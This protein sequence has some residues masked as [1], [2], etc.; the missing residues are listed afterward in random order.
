M[1]SNLWVLLAAACLFW[2]GC[3]R[4]TATEKAPQ[5]LGDVLAAQPRK[6]EFD[7]T[8]ADLDAKAEAATRGYQSEG[9]PTVFTLDTPSFALPVSAGH[10]YRAVVRL[11][12]DAVYSDLAERGVRF[13]VILPG[14]GLRP[15]GG[16]VGPGAIFDLHCASSDGKALVKLSSSVPDLSVTAGVLAKLGSGTATVQ[17]YSRVAEPTDWGGPELKD[18]LEKELLGFAIAASPVEGALD[19]PTSV[20]FPLAAGWC[21]K[22]AVVLRPGA[23]FGSGKV[24]LVIGEAVTRGP[25]SLADLGCVTSDRTQPLKLRSGRGGHGGFVAQLYRKP[26]AT[27]VAAPVVGDN[28]TVCAKCGAERDLCRAQKGVGVCEGAWNTCVRAHSGVSDSPYSYCR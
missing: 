20:S 12:P 14:K 23:A 13:D 4:G 11:G 5:R 2:G 18:L 10:C 8:L 21:Y 1:Q 22:L 6:A 3:R 28:A 9:A 17:L 7:A 19:M 27:G 16:A 15:S 26:G 24:G 25:G